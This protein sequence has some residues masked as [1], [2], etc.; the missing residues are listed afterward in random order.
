MAAR[1]SEKKDKVTDKPDK[2]EEDKKLHKP[3]PK[4]MEDTTQP[5]MYINQKTGILQV[6]MMWTCTKCSYAYNK[7]EAAKCEVCNISRPLSKEESIENGGGGAQMVN[8][9]LIK[10][11]L[12][13]KL[14]VFQ[15]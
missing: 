8:T 7:V 5:I 13:F 2:K 3:L 9:E 12:D 15:R 11:S 14:K 10:V 1:T 6:D 4:A